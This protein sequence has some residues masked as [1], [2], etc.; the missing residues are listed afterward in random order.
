MEHGETNHGGARGFA[1]NEAQREAVEHAGGPLIIL[2]GPGTGKTA[3]MTQRIAHLIEERDAE[4][5]SILALTFTNRAAEQL[6][7]RAA[8]AMAG[9]ARAQRVQASTFHSFGLRL[10]RR[11]ADLIGWRTEPKIVDGARARRLMREIVGRTGIGLRRTPYDPFA[12][13]DAALAFVGRAANAGRSP[14]ECRAC[15]GVQRARLEAMEGESEERRALAVRVARLEELTALYGAFDEECM[16]RGWATYDDLQ[17]R[18]MR[19]LRGEERIRTL[20]RSE[21]KH[22]LVDEFQ[23]VN[24]AQIELLKLIA[25]QDGDVAV[26]GDDDQSIYGFRGAYQGAFATFAEH[27]HGARIV[28]LTQNYR[29]S[30]VVLAAAQGVIE[31]CGDRFDPTKRIE[32]AGPMRAVREAIEMVEYAGKEGHAREIAARIARAVEGG[33]VRAEECAV[34]ARTNGDLPAIQR[35]LTARGIAAEIAQGTRVEESDLLKDF[36][37]WLRVIANEGATQHLVRVLAQGPI[38]IPLAELSA[39]HGQWRK[40]TGWKP[41]EEEEGE[42]ERSGKRVRGPGFL[43]WLRK[44]EQ[45]PEGLVRFLKMHDRLKLCSLTE[46]ADVVVEKCLKETM[47]LELDLTEG[48]EREARAEEMLRF[49]GDVRRVMGDLDGGRSLA[50]L[51]TRLDDLEAARI[52]AGDAAEDRVTDAEAKFTQRDAVRLLT[53]HQAKGLEFD[54]VYVPRINLHGYT[55][56]PVKRGRADDDDRLELAELVEGLFPGGRSNAADEERRVVFV[57][58]TRARKRLCLL[59]Q[60]KDGGGRNVSPSDLWGEIEGMAEEEVPKKYMSYTG[61]KEAEKGEADLAIAG[62]EADARAGMEMRLRLRLRIEA[63]AAMHRAATAERAEDVEAAARAMAE[64]AWKQA[65]LSAARKGQS[66]LNLIIAGAA[67]SASGSSD[68]IRKYGEEALAA[69]DTAGRARGLAGPLRLT[70]SMIEDYVRCPACYRI[71]H[72]LNLP[73]RDERGSRYGSIIHNALERFYRQ[74][75]KHEESSGAIAP[76]GLDD[77][78]TKG[79]AA[80]QEIAGEEEITERLTAQVEAGLRKYHEAMHRAEINPISVEEGIE[81]AFPLDG[82]AHQIRVRFDRLDTDEKGH[83]IID[84]KTGKSKKEYTEIKKTDLQMG[85]YAMAMEA[86]GYDLVG[87]A[88]YWLVST[89]EKGI[90]ELE[91]LNLKKVKENVANAIRGILAGQWERGKECKNGVCRLLEPVVDRE[92]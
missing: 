38:G 82:D 63:Q 79:Q 50:D 92:G 71:K 37:S 29:S 44:R 65:A 41:E 22:V 67:G 83:H 21:I 12:I 14:E 87:T 74:Q 55:L 58:L 66:A 80:M 46:A 34:L 53:A 47:A 26:V 57:A 36:K 56:K 6:R 62:G 28:K 1:L 90:I 89:G 45:Q 23:D 69:L 70:F 16:Q 68:V 73:E 8:G 27:W 3:V 78:L 85:V 76:P 35:A 2:A 30:P 11:Y 61:G 40:E 39:M 81:F 32:A 9:D 10:L 20:V 5:E 59:A 86:A 43:D 72:V 19:M 48:A 33:E 88:E 7:E 13:V 64:S 77:L 60:V 49:V 17:T 51:L 54:H 4:G 84:Y 24:R 42:G 91:A 31:K 25:P 52:A 75:L 18:P 15:A